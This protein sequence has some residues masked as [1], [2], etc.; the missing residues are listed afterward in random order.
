MVFQKLGG[1][2][3][4]GKFSAAIIVLF[5]VGVFG[6]MMYD[7]S[8]MDAET[9]ILCTSNEGGILIPGKLCEHYMFNYRAIES[10]VKELAS[11][12]GLSFILNGENK[13]KKYQIAEYYLSNGLDVNG[14]NQYGNYNLTPLH[15]AVLDNDTEMATFLLRHGADKN[16][17]PP[18]IN[19]SSL[20]FA[21]SLQKKEPNVDR[22]EMIQVLSN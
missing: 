4:K 21:R 3:V 8:K 1:N 15:G 16:I 11:G 14:V 2:A 13:D 7:V 9:I 20:E 6:L 22:N 18:S 17:R 12:A 10:D 19:M 5:L